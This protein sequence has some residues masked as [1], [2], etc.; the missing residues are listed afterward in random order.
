[1]ARLSCVQ[2]VYIS[3]FYII[4]YLAPP[5]PILLWGWSGGATVSG[6]TPS[7]GA[8]YNLDV[9]R[10]RAY[11]VCSRLGGGCLDIFTLLYLSSPLSPSPI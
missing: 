6:Y 5:P 4:Y 10:A 3:F 2:F 7:A 9:S 8:S 11:C 1:M